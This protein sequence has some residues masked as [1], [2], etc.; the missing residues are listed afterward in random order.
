MKHRIKEETGLVCSI[1]LA[2]NKLLAKIAS[3]L[4]KPDGFCVLTPE[5]MLAAV[6][7]RPA[8]L[9]PGVG[10]KTFERLRRAGIKTVA[11]LAGASDEL[12]GRARVGAELRDRARG[13]DNRQVQTSA[14]AQVGELRD[15]VRPRTSP[16]ARCCSRRSTGCPRGC[17]KALQKGGYRGRTVTL[18]DPAAPVPHLHALAHARGATADVADGAAP[19]RTSCS[20]GS[21]STRRCGSSVSGYPRSNA[22]DSDDTRLFAEA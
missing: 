9:L 7:D 5:T 19:S 12:L 20:A 6:G 14:R 21:S 22:C 17:A 18:E 11:D 3:D 15:N 10:P 8:S 2:P 13:I 1:G 16:T 4:D